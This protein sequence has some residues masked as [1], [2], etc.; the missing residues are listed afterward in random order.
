MEGRKWVEG[1]LQQKQGSQ[2]Q[3]EGQEIVW[4]TQWQHGRQEGMQA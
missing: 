1:E 4:H 3:V 2:L